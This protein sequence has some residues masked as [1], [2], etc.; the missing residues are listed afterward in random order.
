MSNKIVSQK[1]VKKRVVE[2]LIIGKRLKDLSICVFNGR[3]DIAAFN[4]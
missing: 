3:I 2:T 4:Q 1:S